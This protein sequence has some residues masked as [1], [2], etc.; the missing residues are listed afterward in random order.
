MENNAQPVSR[1]KRHFI[2]HLSAMKYAVAIIFAVVTFPLYLLLK[3]V[4]TI[5]IYLKKH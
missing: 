3:Y 1:I 2:M 4:F 5:L